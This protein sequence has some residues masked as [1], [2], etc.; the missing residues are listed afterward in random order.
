M[1]ALLLGCGEMGEEAF[2]DLY[3]FGKFDE[4][5]VGTRTVAKACLVAKSMLPMWMPLLLLWKAA[6]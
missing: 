5:I 6:L 1:K 4:L 3:E 2:K